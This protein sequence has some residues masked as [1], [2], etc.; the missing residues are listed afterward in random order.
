M[1]R[2][3]GTKEFSQKR[4]D[5]Q[6]LSK[7]WMS[8]D[9]EEAGVVIFCSSSNVKKKQQKNPITQHLWANKGSKCLSS[10]SKKYKAKKIAPLSHF[11]CYVRLIEYGVWEL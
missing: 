3:T 2:W 7:E 11:P 6:Q 1:Q 4:A 9:T 10:I 5:V 8:K